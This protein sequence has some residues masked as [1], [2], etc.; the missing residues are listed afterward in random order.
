M[1]TD[2]KSSGARSKAKGFSKC[3]QCNIEVK[4]EG[5]AC[6]GCL[7]WFHLKCAEVKN[8]LY[9]E[10]G[11]FESIR[12]ANICWYCGGCNEGIKQ[13]KLVVE[14]LK[15][16]NKKIRE[17]LDLLK[18]A[19]EEDEKVR[20]KEYSQLRKEIGEAGKQIVETNQVTENAWKVA[21]EKKEGEIKQS[22]ADIMKE[23]QVNFLTKAE[24]T[25]SKVGVGERKMIKMEVA[26]EF[27]REKR[28]NKLVIMGIKEQDD[29]GDYE[30]KVMRDIVQALTPD[31]EVEYEV[32]GRIGKKIAGVDRPVRVLVRDVAMR[33]RLLMKARE[34]KGNDRFER[35]YIVPDLTR[36]QQQEDKKLRDEV[37][38]LRQ[39]GQVG[40]KISKGEI[41]IGRSGIVERGSTGGV[42][43]INE[44]NKIDSLPQENGA[45]ASVD[46]QN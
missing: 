41:V 23:E 15:D 20:I 5:V 31:C 46:N 11:A 39:Q 13:L 42:I 26:E 29:K 4:D 9:K 45:G 30:E 28:K 35:I 6:D 16:S 44:A 25:S 34:L 2:K 18:R 36:I 1:S 43:D 17:E 12:G 10:M 22:F 24:G 21:L 14:D 33:R 38:K 8:E 32:L 40:V 27:E 7:E 3:A 37:K 19:R